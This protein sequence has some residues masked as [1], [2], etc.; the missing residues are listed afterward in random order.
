MDGIGFLGINYMSTDCC[1][2]GCTR[3]GF[4]CPAHAKAKNQFDV[5]NECQFYKHGNIAM[6]IDE[7][8]LRET[9]IA[10]FADGWLYM[11]VGA[12]I[13]LLMTIWIF[14]WVLG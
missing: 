1:D 6:Q 11:L 9:L 3:K 7:P 10:F 4:D 12:S 8:S 5:V 14:F 13:T 2:Y